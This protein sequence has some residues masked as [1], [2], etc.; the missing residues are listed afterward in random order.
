[1]YLGNN[2]L[3]SNQL[4]YKT[5]T[6]LV[7]EKLREKIIAGEIKPGE[8]INQDTLAS[9]FNTSKNPIREAL[10]LLKAEGFIT[11]K[12]NKGAMVS[13]TNTDQIDELFSLKVLLET[14]LLAASLPHI[15]DDKLDEAR[16][17]LNQLNLTKSANLW[18]DLNKQY[19]NCLY[20]G[21]KR[22]QT[23]E[24]LTLLTTKIERYNH[25]HFLSIKDKQYKNSDISKLLDYCSQRKI[26][27]AIKQLKQHILNS[28]DEIKLLLQ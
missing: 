1:M 16:Q 8:R 25:L 12:S 20:S 2:M 26:S 27:S 19:Y 9:E 17:I 6:Q 13:V 18:C 4:E 5:L 22:P 23:Q 28:R 7:V 15:L 21:T 11:I 14:D 3:V 10:L 24:M